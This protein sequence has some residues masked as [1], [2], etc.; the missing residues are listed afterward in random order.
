MNIEIPA[1]IY[2]K[3]SIDW[4]ISLADYPASTYTLYFNF[5]NASADFQITAGASGDTHTVTKTAADTSYTAGT[6]QW[7][8][9]VQKTSDATERHYIAKGIID[10]RPDPTGTDP[11]DYRSHYEKMVT[12]LKTVIEGRATKDYDAIT[13]AGRSITMMSLKELRENYA[14]YNRLYLQELKQDKINAGQKPG[15]RFLLQFTK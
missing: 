6:Y 11:L 12:A 2:A 14:Y 4:E 5:R 15:G 7:I 9:Y 10:V 8:A 13:I 3:T 1:F